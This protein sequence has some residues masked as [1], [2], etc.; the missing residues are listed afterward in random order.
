MSAISLELHDVFDFS[1]DEKEFTPSRHFVNDLNASSSPFLIMLVGNGRAGKSTRANQLVRH[2]L[3]VDSPFEAL[4]GS[5]PVTEQFQYCGPFKFGDLSRIHGV[6]LEAGSDPDIFLIDCKGLNS[7]G[8]TTPVLKQATFALSQMVSMNVLVMKDLVNHENIENVRGLFVL[9]HAFSRELPGF[10]IG[11]TVMMRE[12]GIRLPRGKKLTPDERNDLRQKSDKE[13]Q[14]KILEVLNRAKVQFSEDD[15]IV[16]AQPTFDDPDLYWKSIND[17][18]VFTASIAAKRKPISGKS[19]LALFEEAKPSIM[20]IKD[21]SN[22]SIPFE[23][24]MK[25]ITIR[26]LKEAHD[27]SISGIETVVQDRMIQLNSGCLRGGLDTYFVGDVVVRAIHAFEVKAEELFPNSLGYFPDDTEKYRQSIKES[28]ESISNTL[29]VKQCI[30]VVLP[31]LQAEILKGITEAIDAE[32]NPIPIKDIGAFP[33]TDLSFRHEESAAGQLEVASAKIHGDIQ[34]SPEFPNV[35]AALRKQVSIHVKDIE[36]N[37]KAEHAEYIAQ[38]IAR[39]KQQREFQYQEDL[40]RMEA[41]EAA[42]RKA[43]QEER[44][45]AEHLRQEEEARSRFQLEQNRALMEQTFAQQQEHTKV[46]LSMQERAS[47]EQQAMFSKIMEDRRRSDEQAAAQRREEMKLQAERE[48]RL[49]EQ[50]QQLMNRPPT[51]VKS[52]GGCNVF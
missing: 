52:G 51:V 36:T 1:P 3:Q 38:E 17:F 16:L 5:E 32:L 26:Y 27:L 28:V 46:I 42:K 31:D 50:L 20:A 2:E 12:V 19:L 35:V 48:S 29:F 6:D 8:K 44:D 23:E 47:Q 4:S 40:K 13:Q 10:A 30:S 24:I 49:Q 25:R 33:F 14:E 9:S 21:F 41:K 43:L 22:P 11:T 39:E 7:L 34:T 15:F 45:K 37:R 18:L